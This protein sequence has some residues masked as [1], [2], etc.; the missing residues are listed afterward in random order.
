MNPVQLLAW[1]WQTYPDNH[2]HRVNLLIHIVAVPLFLA[3]NLGVVVGVTRLSLPVVGLS[4]VAMVVAMAL[5]GRGHALEAT[6][7]IPF[8]GPFN[9]LGR[10]FLEQ[11][12][13]FPR[14]VFSGDWYR[15]LRGDATPKTGEQRR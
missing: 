2:R 1:Q 11:W 14:Y 7:P 6:P 5:Q 9:A 13:S 8:S 12:V 15:A 4:L 10:I 3:G